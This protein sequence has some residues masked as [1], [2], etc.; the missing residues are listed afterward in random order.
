ML[1]LRYVKERIEGMKIAWWHDICTNETYR[2]ARFECSIY[3]LHN[4]KSKISSKP[5]RN[6]YKFDIYLLVKLNQQNAMI[7]ALNRLWDWSA[8]FINFGSSKHTMRFETL[9]I[10]E[11][12]NQRC[13][14]S[15]KCQLFQI[16]SSQYHVW[17]SWSFEYLRFH[18]KNI[19]M[20]AWRWAADRKARVLTT[21]S[22][23]LH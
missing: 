4:C 23:K 2:A 20:A 21:G 14:E 9:D 10:A 8:L 3:I 16:R 17:L 15:R 13:E 12:T 11:Q 1:V 5:K 22:E 6:L 19:F 7:T 18:E